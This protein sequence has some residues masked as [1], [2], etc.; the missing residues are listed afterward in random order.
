VKLEEFELGKKGGKKHL[1]RKPAPKSWP[2]HRKEFLWAPRPMPG[3]HPI[4]NCIPLTLIVRDILGFAKTRKE[5]KAIISQG[6]LIVNGKIRQEERFPAGLMDVI[7]IPEIKKAY[8]ILPS[9]KGLI[10][11]PIEANKADFKLCRIE[12]KT[13]VKGSH[14]QLNFHDGTNLLFRAEEPQNPK[15]DA[16]ETLDTLKISIPNRE[17]LEYIKLVEGAYALIT[18]GKNAGRYGKIV[19]IE[20]KPGQKRRGLLVTVEDKNGIQFQTVLDYVFAVGSTKPEIS[21]PEVE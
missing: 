19:A 10:L 17:V 12:N 2:I 14:V 7:Y 5:A 20:K 9:K 11:H 6:K 3:P 15:G 16:Y 18:D 4:S 21:L 8:C 1:K 13:I